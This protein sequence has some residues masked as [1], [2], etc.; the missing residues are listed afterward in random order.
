MKVINIVSIGKFN[1]H[2]NLRLPE[3]TKVI[4]K[5]KLNWTIINQETSSQLK[6]Q[7]NKEGKSKTG[8]KRVVITLWQSGSFCISGA[9]TIQETKRVKEIMEKELKRLIPRVFKK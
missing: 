9:T 6:L 8:Q 5:G 2:H 7:F 4:E 1:F 3:V